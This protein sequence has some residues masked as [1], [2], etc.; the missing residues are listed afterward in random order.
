[1][2][3]NT[4]KLDV[5]GKIDRQKSEVEKIITENLEVTYKVVEEKIKKH[6]EIENV[7]TEKITQI[8]TSTYSKVWEEVQEEIR[9]AI[10]DEQDKV[11]R[12]RNIILTNVAEPDTDDLQS[13]K[14][15]D[16]NSV[17]AFFYT[18]MELKP[19]DIIISDTDSLHS[20][21]RGQRP[22]W[23]KPRLLRVRL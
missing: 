23:N 6:Q 19:E 5:E 10:L 17:T 3:R 2:D 21:Q 8:V 14:A 12:S 20:G 11:Y 4:K 7:V 16:L 22:N 1:M 18:K 15:I 13:G 9:V